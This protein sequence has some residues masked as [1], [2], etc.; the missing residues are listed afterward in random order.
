MLGGYDLMPLPYIRLAGLAL[1]AFALSGCATLTTGS[2]QSVTVIT[3][4]SGAECRMEREGTVVAIVNPTPG[5]VQVDK[6]KNAIVVKC[7]ADGFLETFATL[8]S[9]FQ[10]MT[11]GNVLFGGII[12]VAIDAGSGAMN[13]YPSQI[14]LLLIPESFPTEKKR[15]TFFQGA[16][17]RSQARTDAV[18]A[19]IKSECKDDDGCKREVTVA[20]TAGASEISQ[21]KSQ[22]AT[23]KVDS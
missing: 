21:L 3:D 13:E 2:D 9:E 18:I 12:G 16:I 22:W 17:D 10:G 4:P 15:A 7:A 20:E 23:A 8:S 19:K 5:T 1:A 14:T 11:V 6:S